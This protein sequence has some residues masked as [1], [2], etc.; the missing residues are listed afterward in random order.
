MEE[1]RNKARMGKISVL[2]ENKRCFD[3]NARGRPQYVVAAPLWLFVCTGCS[4]LHRELNH[5]VLSLTLH[6]F[7]KDQLEALEGGGNKAAGQ[8]WLATWQ[9]HDFP[10]PQDGQ[11]EKI[12]DFMQVRLG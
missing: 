4:G 10:T 12:R 9:S 2:P 5:R 1:K 11:T 7:T 8:H 6:T 3:C